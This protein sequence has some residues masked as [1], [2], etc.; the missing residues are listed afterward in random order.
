MNLQSFNLIDP[1]DKL[2]PINKQDRIYKPHI[3]VFFTDHD[4]VIITGAYALQGVWWLSVTNISEADE[5]RNIFDYVLKLEPTECANIHSVIRRTNYTDDQLRYFYYILPQ[6]ADDIFEY[7]HRIEL[8]ILETEK[9]GKYY[10]IQ[11]YDLMDPEKPNYMPNP[12]DRLINVYYGE[13]NDIIIVGVADNCYIY[14]FSVT[15]MDDTETNRMILEWLNICVP[16]KFGHGYI[17]VKKT[18]YTYEQIRN[19]YC[20]EIKNADEIIQKRKAANARSKTEGLTI[21]QMKSYIKKC[22][23]AVVI[24]YLI[25]RKM[26][27]LSIGYSLK[28][29][30]GAQMI[31]PRKKYTMNFMS[32]AQAFIMPI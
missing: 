17:A 8:S 31:L 1:K 4:D 23:N 7:Y 22:Q 19:F 24:P 15:K 3:K 32:C 18:R 14:W 26:S 11:K 20:A 9:G 6:T 29:F 2:Y 13:D 25:T 5:I 30:C 10:E 21:K 12:R 16:T 27:S 28:P